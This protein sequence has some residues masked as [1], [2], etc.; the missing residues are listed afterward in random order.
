MLWLF[1]THLTLVDLSVSLF[2]TWPTLAKIR[3]PRTQ[4]NLNFCFLLPLQE[5]GARSSS[6]LTARQ[7]SSMTPTSLSLLPCSRNQ[8]QR[9]HVYYQVGQFYPT[10]VQSVLTIAQTGV[11]TYASPGIFGPVGK[12]IAK[13]A[14][15]GVAWH[16]V[17]H[18]MGE[19]K[20]FSPSV[21]RVI[22]S[23]RFIHPILDHICAQI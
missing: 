15:L 4:G 6:A 7:T 2:S 16:L 11:R 19:Y 1:L 3:L 13:T 22:E 5:M 23:A 10:G 14:D 17:A 21:S 18:V 20:F 9:Q 8:A 12:W